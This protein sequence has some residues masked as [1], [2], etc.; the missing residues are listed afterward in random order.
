LAKYTAEITVPTNVKG[1]LKSDSRTRGKITVTTGNQTS[2]IVESDDMASFKATLNT[3][4]RDLTVINSS[5]SAAEK[6]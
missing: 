1:I 5:S 2:I 3:V 6:G 4:M